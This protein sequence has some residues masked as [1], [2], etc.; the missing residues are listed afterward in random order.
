[1]PPGVCT[2]R[3]KL[4]LLV[5]NSGSP[6]VRQRSA[7]EL[8]SG[9]SRRARWTV[10]PSATGRLLVLAGLGRLQQGETKL[11]L[12]GGNLL[13]LWR[14][15]RN[16]AIGRIDNQRRARAGALEGHKYIVIGP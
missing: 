16:P 1:M 15:R 6:P 8:S 14:Q 10:F 5:P 11:P 12:R 9:P 2:I 4:P 7:S 3:R 13:S